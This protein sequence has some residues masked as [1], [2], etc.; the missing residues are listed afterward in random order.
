[1]AIVI[2]LI[3]VHQHSKA[4][5][6]R[7]TKGGFAACWKVAAAGHPPRGHAPAGPQ[8]RP[9]AAKDQAS[10]GL[11]PPVF[12]PLPLG[13]P[14][15]WSLPHDPTAGSPSVLHGIAPPLPPSASAAQAEA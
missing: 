5:R 6:D 14:K 9:D 4:P 13:H 7:Y 1:M 10:P 8:V 3:S 11:Q 15:A 2:F 12:L